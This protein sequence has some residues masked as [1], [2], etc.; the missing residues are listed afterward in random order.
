M[1]NPNIIKSDENLSRTRRYISIIRKHVRAHI[2][3]KTAGST[4]FTMPRT[5]YYDDGTSIF[6]ER[7]STYLSEAR[8]DRITINTTNGAYVLN[9]L[10]DA[11]ILF[12]D[13]GCGFEYNV[14]PRFNQRSDYIIFYGSAELKLKNGLYALL[15]E[16]GHAIV[17]NKGGNKILTSRAHSEVAAWDEA[18]RLAAEMD[19]ILFENRAEQRLYREL[20]VRTYDFRNEEGINYESMAKRIHL[21]NFKEQVIF[22]LIKVGK[23]GAQLE[24]LCSALLADSEKT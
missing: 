18:E 15:H 13:G 11:S 14:E 6:L 22:D 4:I 16:L 12:I 2:H 17:G 23:R 8:C 21:P 10:I 9:E 7:T 24:G 1:T 5:I 20:C 19:L 3:E